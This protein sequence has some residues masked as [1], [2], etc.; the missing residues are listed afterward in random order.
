MIT[1]HTASHQYDYA[2]H[3]FMSSHLHSHV[4]M[5]DLSFPPHNYAYS[6]ELFL[7]T[8]IDIGSLAMLSLC[9]AL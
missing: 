1:L 9:A 6:H 2:L 4:S 8:L 5:I 3:C 7:L